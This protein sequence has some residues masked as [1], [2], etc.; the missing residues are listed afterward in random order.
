MAER[1]K[2]AAAIIP[3]T[4][5]YDVTVT[6]GPAAGPGAGWFGPLAPLKPV[7]PADV[8]G[9]RWDFPS[10]YNLNVRPRTYEKVGFPELRALADN[11]DLLRIVIET[12]KDQIERRRWTIRPK[13]EEFGVGKTK[14][15]QALIDR[16]KDI[17]AFFR[18]PDQV[19]GWKPW[20]RELIE[21][22][23]VYDAP[24]IYKRPTRGGGLYALEVI[25]GATIVPKID[26]SG[27]VVGYQQVLK[28]LPAVDYTM[29][30]L[31]YRPRNTRAD[32]VYGFSPVEQILMTVNIALR[33]QVWQ[34]QYFTEGN[35]P[36][37]LIGVP[38]TW[39]PDQIAQFQVWWDDIF[40]GNTAQRR[41]AKFVPS[42]V[43]KT[44]IETKNPELFNKQD[45]WLAR[46][47]C[48]C[49]SISPQ[50]FVQMMNRAT[51]ET[52]KQA[53]TEEGVEP[54]LDWIKDNVDERIETDL[55]EPDA[56][57]AWVEEDAVDPQTQEAVTT[58]YVKNALLTLN[59]GRARIGEERSTDPNADKLG[60]ITANGFVPL[61]VSA[62]P[63]PQ[64]GE[65]DE[66]SPPGA[67][68]PTG[69][70]KP[71]NGKGG[72]VDEK[73]PGVGKLA[74]TP[75]FKRRRRIAP[76]TPTRKAAVDAAVSLRDAIAPILAK[77]GK[78]IVKQ[79]RAKLKD[80][81]LVAKAE[82]D[83]REQRI[84]DLAAA[85]SSE[86]NLD[87]LD[88]LVDVTSDQIA[89]FVK[90][91]AG[92][93]LAQL[94]V[95]ADKDLVDQVNERAVEMANE[96]AAE[97]VGKSYVDG[98][99]VDNPDAEFR[100][101]E[102]TRTLIRNVI[103]DG[104]DEN[105]GADEIAS[106]IEDLGFDADRADLIART[107][108]ARANSDAALLSYD[109]AQDAGVAVRKEWI[110]GPNPCEICEGNAD[111]GDIA[112]DDDFSSGDDAPP[113]H[114]NCECAVS[115]VVDDSGD[116]GDE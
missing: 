85:I 98:E 81:D 21:Q 14:P 37:S 51:G 97:L 48:F 40:N 54:T 60:V 2:G 82:G 56:E 88:A 44:F 105:L 12:R 111:D 73:N 26:D 53:S 30:E 94:G 109:A 55:K 5:G 39:T 70:K 29:D 84:R 52:A 102:G 15:P 75:F 114:P 6:Y 4:P 107:E 38:E 50:P 106:N 86:V 61:E 92:D 112:I 10:G 28:G 18:K 1:D 76:L 65:V 13:Q 90:D 63:P 7:A 87:G 23:F 115:P 47:V 96:R 99:L 72:Q 93:V 69:G 17:K 24:T 31:I 36:D 43:G 91:T 57:F 33:R 113:A 80:S 79:V 8:A 108:I 41:Q 104:L 71:N 77:A 66:N 103:T 116:E 25:D 32:R 95:E 59:E 64:P 62:Q 3:L 89:E 22:L 35:I 11:Y 42:G 34:L 9:R 45:E 58:G 78:G 19:R 16:C 101:D 83:D 100:I 110:L 27:R 20:L 46:I 68:Q 49:F 67:N 74:R